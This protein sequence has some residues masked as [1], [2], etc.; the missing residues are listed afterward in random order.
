MK[1]EESS[2]SRRPQTLRTPAGDDYSGISVYKRKW[3]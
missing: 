3:G 1:V 2:Y